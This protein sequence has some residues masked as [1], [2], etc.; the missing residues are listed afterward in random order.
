MMAL[1]RLACGRGLGPE[2][3]ANLPAN[4]CTTT[5]SEPNGLDRSDVARVEQTAPGSMRSTAIDLLPTVTDTV[6]A[7]GCG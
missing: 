2:W 5:V 4:C 1:V 3:P 7:Q 6:V